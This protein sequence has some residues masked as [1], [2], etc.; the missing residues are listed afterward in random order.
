MDG[1]II[2]L[3]YCIITAFPFFQFYDFSW[4]IVCNK[5][6]IYDFSVWPWTC[7]NVANINWI[8]SYTGICLNPLEKFYFMFLKNPDLSLNLQPFGNRNEQTCY[9]SVAKLLKNSP[10]VSLRETARGEAWISWK[11]FKIDSWNICEDFLGQL[12]FSI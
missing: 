7:S 9:L 10:S 1:V 4:K 2:F 11:L 12:A 5:R 8:R 6:I 3:F